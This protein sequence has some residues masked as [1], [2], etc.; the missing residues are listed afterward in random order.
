MRRMLERVRGRRDAAALEQVPDDTNGESDVE[1]PRPEVR[2]D[3]SQGG[4][5]HVIEEQNTEQQ[6]APDVISPCQVP[7]Q[8]RPPRAKSSRRPRYTGKFPRSHSTG[9][10]LVQPG[11]NCDRFTLRLPE[12]VRKQ[13]MKGRLNR[14]TS[15][16][17]FPTEGSTRRGYRSGGEGSSRGKSYNNN[18]TTSQL[19][20]GMDRS[21][22]S[23]RWVF[24]MTPPFFTRTFSTRSAKAGADGEAATTPK[25]FFTS[26][27][28]PFDCL[29]GKPEGAE[30]SSTR[31]PV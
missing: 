5:L 28:T 30:S 17:A 29:G 25:A 4:S 11:E 6:A 27:K 18:N 12:E 24:S 9:H 22:K 1:N 13:I 3:Q 31:P 26:V 7:I 8:N 16:V 2:E 21:A 20:E 15:C 23:D 14:T 10:S 19:V